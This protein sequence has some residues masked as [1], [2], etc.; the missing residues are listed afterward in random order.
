MP[1][2]CGGALG[3]ARRLVIALVTGEKEGSREFGRR[4]VAE[5]TETESR[6][7]RGEA[8]ESL[9][10]K[11]E[12]E[13]EPARE[14]WAC[15]GG[16]RGRLSDDAVGG[17]ADVR[18][19]VDDSPGDLPPH[20]AAHRRRGAALLCRAPCHFRQRAGPAALQGPRRGGARREAG[21]AREGRCALPEMVCC[22]G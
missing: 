16:G 9:G 14:V 11:R 15:G 13:R 1:E 10:G 6:G 22:G 18:D 17:A 21:R 2:G 4:S 19:A 12:R 3:G 7:S 8:A 20:L 5:G